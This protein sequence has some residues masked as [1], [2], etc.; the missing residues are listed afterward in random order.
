MALELELGRGLD[1]VLVQARLLLAQARVQDQG[2][3]PALKQAPPL[4]HMLGQR[5]DP[6]AKAQ[7]VDMVVVEVEGMVEDPVVEVA[8]VLEVA[9]V[10][11]VAMAEDM[12]VVVVETK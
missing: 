11:V 5:V 2:Q 7:G 8:R 12:E 4:G 10:K 9:M 1:Q 3:E 6:V